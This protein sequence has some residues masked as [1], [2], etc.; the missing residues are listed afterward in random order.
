MRG[1]GDVAYKK[2]VIQADG[3]LKEKLDAWITV[4]LKYAEALI[5]QPQV[6][7]ISLGGN[8]NTGGSSSLVDLLT[9]KQIALDLDIKNN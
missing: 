6:P 4:N 8:I 7:Q 1:E 3:A 9:A 2:A 5:L